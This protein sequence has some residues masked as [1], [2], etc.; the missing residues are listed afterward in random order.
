MTNLVYLTLLAFCLPVE[1][2]INSTLGTH[3]AK[4][5]TIVLCAYGITP[6]VAKKYQQMS[7]S[8]MGPLPLFIYS[9]GVG[10]HKKYPS[11][12]YDMYSI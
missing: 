6:L 4:C 2:N 10:L 5:Y 11:R 7:M 12:L 1:K 3:R 8:T 9:R